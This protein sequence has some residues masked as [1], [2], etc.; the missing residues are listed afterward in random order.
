MIESCLN[1]L[2]G[3]APR[4]LALSLCLCTAALAAFG[5]AAE[6]TLRVGDYIVAVVNSELVTAYEVEQRSVRLREDRKG[7]YEPTID[8]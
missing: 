7:P 6:R 8:D 5:Q 2:G 1:R 3:A 4:R